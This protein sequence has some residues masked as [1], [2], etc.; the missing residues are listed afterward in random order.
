MKKVAARLAL[1]LLAVVAASHIAIIG[2]DDYARDIIPAI[3][4]MAG[5]S[6][7]ILAASWLVTH[8]ADAAFPKE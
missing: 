5:I 3:C 4:G 2:T 6:I 8:L 7:V 1:A